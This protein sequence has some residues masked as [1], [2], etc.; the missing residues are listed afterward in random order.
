[1]SIKIFL[2]LLEIF[3]MCIL[4]YVGQKK[5]KNKDKLMKKSVL[6]RMK[7]TMHTVLQKMR[8]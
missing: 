2:Y 3:D 8:I 7:D 1:M 4:M 6:N 5:K